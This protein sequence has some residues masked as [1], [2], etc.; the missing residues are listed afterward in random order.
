MSNTDTYTLFCLVQGH[1]NIFHVIMS[2]TAYISEL[3]VKIKEASGN[4]LREI[5]SH[6]LSLLK[7]RYL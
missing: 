1:T 3:R 2:S 7:V 6:S 4:L 5:D